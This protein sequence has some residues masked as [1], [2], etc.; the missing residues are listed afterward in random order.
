MLIQVKDNSTLAKLL[1]TE[2]IHVTYKNART[3][4]F[5]VKTRELVI[6]IMK[7]MSKDIQDLMT[8]HEVGH[9]LFTSL[10]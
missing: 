6:P 10:A 9:A 4:S 2:D 3:A 8:L 7:E 5:D 1:A